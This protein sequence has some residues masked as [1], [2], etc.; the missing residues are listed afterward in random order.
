MIDKILIQK[1]DGLLFGAG[2]VNCRPWRPLGTGG[3]AACGWG[4]G[5]MLS[6]EIVM[7]CVEALLRL[8]AVK[9]RAEMAGD[10]C[11]DV[12]G[13]IMMNQCTPLLLP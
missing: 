7:L 13:W 12:N 3:D 4:V 8:L 9:S 2:E 11:D 5:P 10:R 1:E 6:S